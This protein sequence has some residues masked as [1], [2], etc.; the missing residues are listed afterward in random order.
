M[1]YRPL[2]MFAKQTDELKQLISEHPDYPIVVIVSS[3]VVA[4]D[5]YAWWY[6]PCIRFGIGE[7]LD[8][9]QDIDEEKTYIDRDEF[10]EDMYNKY[11]DDEEYENLDDYE[12]DEMIENKLK[13]YEPYWRKVIQI[14]A[15][16]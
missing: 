8:C 16:V 3:D 4:D 2:N 9:E 11:E 10:E 12:F 5:G 13:E 7:I 15:D 14:R 1:S 6:A